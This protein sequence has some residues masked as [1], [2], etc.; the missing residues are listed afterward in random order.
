LNPTD[1]KD[2]GQKGTLPA[3][4]VMLD[5]P[6][7]TA[8]LTPQMPSLITIGDL[9]AEENRLVYIPLY[10]F[11]HQISGAALGA[12]AYGVIGG[13]VGL[14]ADKQD[15]DNTQTMVKAFRGAD[16][17]TSL[18]ERIE[19][20]KGVVIQKGEILSIKLLDKSQGIRISLQ[21]GDLLLGADNASRY[22]QQLNDWL[23]GQLQ[24]QGDGQGANL[25]LPAAAT[26]IQWLA[27][28]EVARNL[29]VEAHA[30]VLSE[31]G[32]LNGLLKEFALKQ[33]PVKV[34]ILKNACHLS[35]RWM[36]IFRDHLE[37]ARAKARQRVWWGAAAV[38][39]GIL[40]MCIYFL[41]PATQRASSNF[42]VF[43][44]LLAVFSFPVWLMLISSYRRIGKL[45]GM[46]K[47][48]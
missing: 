14:F 9:F 32:Y 19:K 33:F 46:T 35:D 16:Y 15:L 23:A 5:L 45:I 26:L 47:K 7:L 2:D 31:P 25:A 24:G 36:T 39:L 34:A 8:Q 12:L 27:K 4:R 10:S 41:S 13:L 22:C 3:D 40:S 37:G 48:D 42:L 1:L 18:A 17:G 6:G 28:N 20:H 43:G 38:G 11:S 21:G 30:S 44:F 29:S